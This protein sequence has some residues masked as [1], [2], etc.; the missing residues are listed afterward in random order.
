M[1]LLHEANPIDSDVLRLSQALGVRTCETCKYAA[2]LGQHPERLI[3]TNLVAIRALECKNDWAGAP[4]Y[5][6]SIER[7]HDVGA[8]KEEGLLWTHA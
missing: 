4:F 5:H 1:Q 6:A 7:K 2:L 8:C 3:C